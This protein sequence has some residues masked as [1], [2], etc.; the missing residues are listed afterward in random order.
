M[1]DPA[2]VP[3]AG[4][5]SA[6]SAPGTAPR[7]IALVTGGTSGV[8]RSML[9]A[10]ISA[11]YFVYFIGSSEARGRVVEAE[12]N[13]EHRAGGH[14][15][16]P[17]CAFQPLDMSKLKAVQAFCQDF[18]TRVPHLNLLA[19]I[20]GVVLPQRTV[21][22]ETGLEKTLSIGHLAAHLLTREMVRN[23]SF[24]PCNQSHLAC[25]L[26]HATQLFGVHSLPCLAINS[27]VRLIVSCNHLTCI[28]PLFS[29]PSGLR[30]PAGRHLTRP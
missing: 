2:P 18:A 30:S 7:L 1:A 23:H 16:R 21:E 29:C 15:E 9:P 26:C 4:A 11:G 13:A 14:E 27:R 20:A 17:V 22:A 5:A 24:A 12:L 3:I 6:A 10:L 8:G 25:A 28:Q 19:N